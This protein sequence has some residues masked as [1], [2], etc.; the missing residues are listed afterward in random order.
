MKRITISL[1]DELGAAVE[2][3]AHRRRVPVSRVIREKLEKAA[4]APSGGERAI[5][6]AAIGRSGHHDTAR[7]I[8]EILDAEWGS[9]HTRARS[10]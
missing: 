3:E 6:F 5:S 8:D 1:P 7:K 9:R 4:T 10:R 2:R